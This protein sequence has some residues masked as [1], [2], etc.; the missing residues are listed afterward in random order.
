M[1]VAREMVRRGLDAY[2]LDAYRVGEGV[3]WR[4][5]IGIAFELTSD[6]DGVARIPRCVLPVDQHVHRHH[7]VGHR[8]ADRPGARRTHARHACRTSRDSR[9]DS[10]R[11]A[12]RPTARRGSSRLRIDRTPHRGGHLERRPERRPGP[13]RWGSRGPRARRR[14]G[15]IAERAGQYGDPVGLGAWRRHRR[16]QRIAAIGQRDARRPHRDRTDSQ[17]YRR[18]STQPLRRDHHPAA[19]GPVAFTAADRDV[20]RRPTRRTHHCRRR[21]RR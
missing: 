5:L 10:R 1:G 16:H 4:R 17:R 14:R 19:D 7:V 15:A 9:P 12:D 3:A 21:P 6:P 2:S 8:G 20:H 11:S 13:A 18:I